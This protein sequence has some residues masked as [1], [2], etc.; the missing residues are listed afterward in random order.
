MTF[1]KKRKHRHSKLHVL[2]GDY[3]NPRPCLGLKKN[4]LTLQHRLRNMSVF[5]CD[6]PCLS[7][8]FLSW[9]D[10]DDH[11]LTRTLEHCLPRLFFVFAS[12]QR[13]WVVKLF[14]RFSS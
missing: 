1:M 13:E 4:S 12:D 10:T 11:G 7:R 9:T 3:K 14:N 2:H 5:V 8:L 6:S